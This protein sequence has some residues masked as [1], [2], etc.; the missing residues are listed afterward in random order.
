LFDEN[1]NIKLSDFGLSKCLSEL[2]TYCSTTAGT[3]TGFV[4]TAHWMAPEVV[5][6]EEYGRK[7]DVWYVA[8]I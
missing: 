2:S 6:G 4:G 5:S 8:I 7:A 1:D 3:H